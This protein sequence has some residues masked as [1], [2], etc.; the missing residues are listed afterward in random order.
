L[1]SSL[2]ECV[3]GVRFEARPGSAPLALAG[4][5][6]VGLV[7]TLANGD[8]CPA[9][10]TTVASECDGPLRRTSL[11]RGDFRTPDGDRVFQFRMR[12]SAYAGSSRVRL[13]P[14]I[15]VDAAQYAHL[16]H[17]RADDRLVELRDVM[18]TLLD[19]AGVPIPAGVEGTSLLSAARRDHV[20]GE[21]SENERASRMLRD[22][23][24][25]L[26]YYPIGNRLQLF[27]LREDPGELRDLSEDA[28][29]ASAR[30][31][32]TEKLIA[33]LYG[34]DLEWL[35]DGRLVGLPERAYTPLTSRPMANQRGWRFM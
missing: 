30:A 7:L 5:V 28:T 1:L 24:Y 9:T 23:R 21:H 3:D 31:A 35:K 27:D 11:V 33:H 15:L 34:N 17:H 16:G 20:Y 8:R 12:V 13:E 10:A 29:H 6:G 19:M 18:P 25:K 4:D 22:E 14:L 26:I 32:L 2:A